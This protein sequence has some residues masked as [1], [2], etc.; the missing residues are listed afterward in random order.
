MRVP[1]LVAA[2]SVVAAM[3][4]A[5]LAV[6]S[7]AAPKPKELLPNLRPLPPG[8]LFGPA[9]GMLPSFGRY[10]PVPVVVDGC[11]P[12]EIVRKSVQRCLR[13]PTAV[14]NLGRGPLELHYR[15]MAPVPEAFQIIY[16]R[17]GSTRAR[18]AADSELHATHSHFHFPNFYVTELWRAD[19]SGRVRSEGPVATSEKS[20]FCPEDS[21]GG[22]ESRYTCGAE[23]SADSGTVAQ[24][25][26]IS[27]GSHDIYGM[28][29][30]DQF[31]E[32]SG[33]PDGFYVLKVA[34]DPDDALVESDESDNEVCVGLELE[35]PTAS[36]RRIVRCP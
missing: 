19:P 13:Y 21:G 7:A 30:P 2:T 17:D 22:G 28:H 14:V 8:E 35:G 27:P 31:V 6:P 29:L 3:A 9:T 36:L 25:V 33:V 18:Y 15:V 16:A 24:I 1:R 12:D 4:W 23:Y 11:L 26:G 10:N 20:G 34:I 32:V 5:F